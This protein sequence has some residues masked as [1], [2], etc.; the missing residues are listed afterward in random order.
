VSCE[1][2]TWL[3]FINLFAGVQLYGGPRASALL[4]IAEAKSFHTEYSSLA[5]TIEIVDDVF[6]AIDH[7][8]HH[9]R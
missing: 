6:A 4:K 5:C 8:H 3:L 9:G 1:I 7:I 2:I